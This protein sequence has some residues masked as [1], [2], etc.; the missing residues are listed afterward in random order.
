MPCG[1]R[2]R[3]HFTKILMVI[4][5]MVMI[6]EVICFLLV[7]NVK[8]VFVVVNRICDWIDDPNPSLGYISMMSDKIGKS[9]FLVLHDLHLH[10]EKKS[11]V[12]FSGNG[13]GL[14]F[15][16]GD[17]HKPLVFDYCIHC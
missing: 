14:F 5:T 11:Q 15:S 9:V 8:L 10:R 16:L 17:L 12:C 4:K 2:R 7:V 13:Q 6:I 1:V 3:C